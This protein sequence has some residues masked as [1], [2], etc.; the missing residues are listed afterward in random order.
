MDL[1]GTWFTK[2]EEIDVVELTSEQKEPCNAVW[3]VYS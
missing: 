1:E 3:E 2:D